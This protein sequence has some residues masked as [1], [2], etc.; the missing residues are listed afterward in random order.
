MRIVE[1]KEK[2]KI[3]ISLARKKNGG[4]LATMDDRPSDS[5]RME[6]PGAIER[7]SSLPRLVGLRTKNTTKILSE[8]GF[9]ED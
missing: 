4:H 7:S 8:A 9:S 3:D 2:S 1:N 6:N 5:R